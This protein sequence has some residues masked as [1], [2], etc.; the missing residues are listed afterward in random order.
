VLLED[1]KQDDDQQGLG[2][3]PPGRQSGGQPADA[4]RGGMRPHTPRGTA[5]R[6]RPG[7]ED[8]IRAH[9]ILKIR[10]VNE[11]AATYGSPRVWL[12][13]RRQGVRVGRKRVI[14]RPE[15]QGGLH[16]LVRIVETTTSGTW[17][18]IRED[19]QELHVGTFL[20]GFRS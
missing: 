12:E 3:K 11:F 5:R 19:L 18:Q 17:N 1:G 20:P 6:G 14:D 13:L 7:L 16:V 4:G 2:L 10:S 8:R 15:L 9:V